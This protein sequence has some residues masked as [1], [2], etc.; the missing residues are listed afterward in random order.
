MGPFSEA[1]SVAQREGLV[2]QLDSVLVVRRGDVL[3]A[4]VIS[5]DNTLDEVSHGALL[6]RRRLVL[7]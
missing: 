4:N 7:I 5:G 3:N 1:Y 2:L 6:P